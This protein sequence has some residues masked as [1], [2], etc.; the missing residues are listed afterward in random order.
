LHETNPEQ[1]EKASD[2]IDIT[3]ILDSSGTTTCSIS[4]ALLRTKSDASGF[5]HHV[6]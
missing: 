5:V 4:G 2:I 3:D 6:W 1:N